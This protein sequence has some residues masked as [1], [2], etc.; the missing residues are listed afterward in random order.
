MQNLQKRL[1]RVCFTRR[2]G[3]EYQKRIMSYH[4]PV[5]KS[6]SRFDLKPLDFGTKLDECTLKGLVD[7]E[8]KSVE[9]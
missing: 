9:I 5:Q 2:S 7:L 6:Y 4:L 1:Q 3:T 8:A